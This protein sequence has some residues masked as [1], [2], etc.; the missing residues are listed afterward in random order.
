MPQHGA[1][2]PFGVKKSAFEK[3]VGGAFRN[4]A[5]GAAKY[6]ANTHGVRFA[7]ADDQIFCEKFAVHCIEAFKNGAF[8][9]GFYHDFTAFN[10]VGIEGKGES[11]WLGWFVYATLN[12]FADV[13]DAAEVTGGEHYRQQA[14]VVRQAIEAH[15]WD[16]AWYRRAYYDDGAPLGSAQNTECRIDAIAQSWAVLS[17][18]GDSERTRQA[19]DALAT[20]L[21]KEEG[22]LLLLFTPALDKTPR[23]PGYIKGYLPGIRENGGQYTHAAQWSIWA[24]AELG[25]TARAY[26]LFQMINPILRSD[27]PAKV[28]QYKV[29]PYV[30]SADVY[31]IAPHVGR[32]GWTWY[33][34]SAAWMY[35]VGVEALLGLKLTKSTLRIQ[36]RIP[37]TWPGYSVKWKYKSSEYLIRVENPSGAGKD[38]HTILLDGA[39]C[40]GDEI[41]LQDDGRQHSVIVHL[42]DAER[43]PG[44]R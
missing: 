27:T 33:T 1:A 10:L 37:A 21:V 18:A 31:N 3:Y 42:G 12:T 8:R 43:A 28:E 41:P 19:M 7:I 30:I 16:G 5:G 20:Y 13:C 24:F 36:P 15:G 38:V 34:G 11:I 35:R 4:A 32:G 25:D 6:A 29:E 22:R 14:E 44:S 23:D 2:D 9:Q 39:S 26:H 40:P 17:G